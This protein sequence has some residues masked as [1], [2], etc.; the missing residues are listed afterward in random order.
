MKCPKCSHSFS[1]ADAGMPKPP[2][3]PNTTVRSFF[4]FESETIRS[5]TRN[6]YYNGASA[7]WDSWMRSLG[8]LSGS[9]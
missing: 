9:D 1:A 7:M 8:L 4:G 6:A 2:E 5:K 3:P